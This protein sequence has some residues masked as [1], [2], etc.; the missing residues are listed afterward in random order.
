[1]TRIT[2]KEAAERLNMPMNAIRYFVRK[3]ELPIGFCMEGEGRGTFYLYRELVDKYLG[4]NIE[5]SNNEKPDSGSS[6]ELI[7][8]YRGG[9]N[10][11]R[12]S[13]GACYSKGG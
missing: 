8:R 3:R 7:S 13:V 6:I 9:S 10:A 1:M 4:V 12:L 11:D 2:V 5:K